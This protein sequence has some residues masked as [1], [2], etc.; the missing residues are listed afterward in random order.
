MLRPSVTPTDRK[1]F[2]KV[3][4]TSSRASQPLPP[5]PLR[6]RGGYPH[7]CGKRGAKVIS[8]REAES[9]C[10]GFAFDVPQPS[11]SGQKV[12]YVL[13]VAY[14]LLIDKRKTAVNQW[15]TTVNWCPEQAQTPQ[16]KGKQ[17]N[18]ITQY[19][20]KLAC[21]VFALDCEK[22]PMLCKK[23]IPCLYPSKK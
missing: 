11:A 12:C 3:T 23:F 8:M 16:I 7:S 4:P 6:G 21:G 19:I 9:P 13:I 20:S 18:L 1:N 15:L 22:W 5:P 10:G 17:K 2:F 14:W